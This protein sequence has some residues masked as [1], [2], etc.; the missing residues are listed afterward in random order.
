MVIRQS[1][2]RRKF[3]RESVAQ[4]QSEEII[5]MWQVEHS[6]RDDQDILNGSTF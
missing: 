1:N 5:V 3:V 2:P 6:S 4:V